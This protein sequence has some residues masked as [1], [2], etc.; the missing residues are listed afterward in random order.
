VNDV[1][2]NIVLHLTLGCHIGIVDV[3]QKNLRT[4]PKNNK[5]QQ[6]QLA[7]TQVNDE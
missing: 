3:Y 1:E 2:R 5:R 4:S 7:P 6:L